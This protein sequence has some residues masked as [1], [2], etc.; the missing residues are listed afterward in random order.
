MVN[1]VNKLTA[2]SIAIVNKELPMIKIIKAKKSNEH[3]PNHM[4]TTVQ[5]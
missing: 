3:I 2:A 5:A 4:I 1:K